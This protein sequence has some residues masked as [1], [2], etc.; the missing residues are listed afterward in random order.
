MKSMPTPEMTKAIQNNIDRLTISVDS[1]DVMLKHQDKT[2]MDH[3][4]QLRGL[5]V[6]VLNI[7]PLLFTFI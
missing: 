7:L 3:K 4:E 1:L 6:T 2:T 5:K